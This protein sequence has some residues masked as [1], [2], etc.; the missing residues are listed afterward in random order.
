M[1]LPFTNLKR[2][3]LLFTPSY[4]RRTPKVLSLYLDLKRVLKDLV[5]MK[6]VT[7]PWRTR[8][9]CSMSVTLSLECDSF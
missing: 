9:Y 3:F 2:Y 7:M 4:F 5:S 1:G 6:K 8:A